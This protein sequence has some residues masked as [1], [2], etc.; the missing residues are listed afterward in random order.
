MPLYFCRHFL[1]HAIT[2]RNHSNVV[3]LFVPDVFGD[4]VLHVKF[5]CGSSIKCIQLKRLHML[6]LWNIHENYCKWLV[7]VHI[8]SDNNRNAEAAV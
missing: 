7:V 8:A 2:S 5:L 4:I 6:Q 3:M 1:T